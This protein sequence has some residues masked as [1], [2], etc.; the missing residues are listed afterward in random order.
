L[1]L[2]AGGVI[3]G[4][5][6]F[7]ATG[8]YSFVVQVTDA[9]GRVAT[10]TL[11]IAIGAAVT[12]TTASLPDGVVGASYSQS[13]GASGGTSPYNWTVVSGQLP[14]G[15]ALAK[16]GQISGTPAATGAST[17]MMQVADSTPGGALTAQL[18]FTLGIDTPLSIGTASALPSATVGT[19]YSATLQVSG[20]KPSYAWSIVSGT[21][22]AGLSLNPSSGLIAGTPSASGTST[23]MAAVA[24]SGSQSVQKQFSIAVS[25]NQSSPLQI[26]TGNLT[27]T[28]G[29]AFSQTL[30]ASGGTAPYSFALTSGTLPAGLTFTAATATI[31]GT[32]TAAGASNLSFTVTDSS[33]QTASKAITFTVSSATPPSATVTVGTGSSSVA[34]AQQL[35]VNISLSGTYP[36]D[37]TV[38]MAVTFQSS[39]GGSDQTVQFIT[40]SGGTTNLTLTITAGSLAP[41]TA[42]VLATG[43]TAGTIT[44]TT[45][46]S[47]PGVTFPQPSPTTVT[48]AK[49]V[50]VIQSVAFSNTGG[51]LTVTVI[52]YSTTRDMVSGDFNFA[53]ATGS[54]LAQS[55]IQV[56]LGSAFSTWY[57]NASSSAFGSQFKLTMPFTVSGNAAN[58]ISVTVKLTNSFGTSIAVSPQ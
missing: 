12:I 52:G 50:P 31:S 7:N 47:S 14:A 23:F 4:T 46:L 13:L 11:S 42:P 51:A 6:A 9:G 2:S 48:I 54:T 39:V 30:T 19:Q 55:D 58:V 57:Q 28:V 41:A 3:S 27:A 36:A 15:L 1:T 8:V 24:D 25:P 49:G 44:I 37:I 26:T 29:V 20:G 43:T 33:G 16:T 56:Q 32:P 35:P 53:P 34:P 45:Q 10:K 18:A 40:S 38:T 21:L 17:F 5:I 22:P